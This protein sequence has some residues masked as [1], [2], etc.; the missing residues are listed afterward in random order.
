MADPLFSLVY[1]S[2]TTDVMSTPELTALLQQCHTNNAQLGITGMLLY[3]DGNV[4]QVLEGEESTVRRVYDRISRDPRHRG[5]LVLH[6]G[7]LQERQFPDWTMGFR[8]LKATDT[9]N[10]PGYSEFLNA[11]L[12]GAEFSGDPSRYQRL[13]MTFK[14]TM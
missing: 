11:P 1:V 7:P 12:T 5:L 10:T 3:K 13:L 9:I 6:Q 14:K 2:S 4:M 8:D